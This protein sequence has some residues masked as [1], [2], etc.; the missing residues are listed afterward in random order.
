MFWVQD[1]GGDWVNLTCCF[2]LTVESEPQSD[3]VPLYQLRASSGSMLYA[4]LVESPDKAVV[5][6]AR[7]AL[8]ARLDTLPASV[9]MAEGA[10][11]I[12]ARPSDQSETTPQAMPKP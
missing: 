7:D 3:D 9:S 10:P 4:V 1:H 6:Q 5:Q 11:V 2:S 8:M 12:P